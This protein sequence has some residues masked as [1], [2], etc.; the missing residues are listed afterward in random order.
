M[1]LTYVIFSREQLYV[2]ILHILLLMLG[3]SAYQYLNV[4]NEIVPIALLI[5]RRY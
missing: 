1:F 4:L 5:R 2:L 3:L